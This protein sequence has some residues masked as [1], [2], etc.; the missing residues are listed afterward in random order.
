M[1]IQHLFSTPIKVV[2]F[3][4]YEK[5]NVIIRKAQSLKFKTNFHENL[6]EE[7]K[8]YIEKVFVDE[9][10]AYMKEAVGKEINLK[11]VMSWTRISKQYGFDTPHGH[12]GDNA[13]LGVY[14][15]D[16][17][18]NSG[19]LLLHD[20]RGPNCFIQMFENGLG[21]RMYYRFKPKTGD[22]ILFPAYIIHSVEPNMNEAIRHSLAM[23][24]KYKYYDQFK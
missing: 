8:N 16:V 1:T 3:P 2:H 14:Y 21:G 4:N 10:D 17:P 11:L 12:G 15:M 9:A 5:L 23:N 19:D 7:E 18:E 24:F 6:P 13:V 20:M 22:L